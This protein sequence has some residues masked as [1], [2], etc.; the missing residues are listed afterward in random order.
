[1]K[2]LVAAAALLVVAGCADAHAAETSAPGASSQPAA[3]PTARGTT[4][5]DRDAVDADGVARRGVALSKDAPAVPVAVAFAKSKEL[6]GKTVKVAGTVDAVCAKK[7]CWFVVKGDRPDQTIRITAKDYGFFV[8]KAA[9]GKA[10]VV[11]GLLE[12]KTLDPATAQHLEDE[13]TLAPGE[14]R[15]KIAGDTV[16]LSIVAA[17]LEL[18]PAT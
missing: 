11:E 12:V 9:K 10:A 13:R 8:P 7:G 3:A 18:K 14:Q 2:N 16:E 1:M 5:A 17:A 6:Q 15:K 4:P